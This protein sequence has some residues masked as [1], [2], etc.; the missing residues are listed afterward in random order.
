MSAPIPTETALVVYQ[1]GGSPTGKRQ[2]VN[3]DSTP[4]GPSDSLQDR[5]DREYR[6][7][8]AKDRA[9]GFP[10]PDFAKA[11]PKE[12]YESILRDAIG[13]R[14]AENEVFRQSAMVV[15][16][17]FRRQMDL[18]DKYGMNWETLLSAME[19]YYTM[20]KVQM[21]SKDSNGK[22]SNLRTN[23]YEFTPKP[24]AFAYLNK[25]VLHPEERLQEVGSLRVQA[26]IMA[27]PE[28]ARY[29]GLIK[30]MNDRMRPHADTI[31]QA[32]GKGAWPM[33]NQPFGDPVPYRLES[34][35]WTEK[36]LVRYREELDQ[37]KT[38]RL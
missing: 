5:T 12:D 14:V 26:D 9:V 17:N 25:E 38:P 18:I 23:S 8:M 34:A 27:S 4:S 10:A 6:Q 3:F 13:E 33:R 28:F 37:M 22:Y 36:T 21:T 1:G 20:M 2:K 31:R 19:Y 30:E 29:R 35:A 32:N 24:Y 11:G 15:L 7:Q 16:R